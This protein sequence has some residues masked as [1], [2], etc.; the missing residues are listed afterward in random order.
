MLQGTEY[1]LTFAAFEPFSTEKVTLCEPNHFPLCSKSMKT[2]SSMLSIQAFPDSLP[3]SITIM[4]MQ[5]KTRAIEAQLT[6]H[7]PTVK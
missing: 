3:G 2:K 1:K 6:M 4:R 7:R 5:K